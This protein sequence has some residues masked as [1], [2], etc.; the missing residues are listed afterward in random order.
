M[1][2]NNTP[3]ALLAKKLILSEWKDFA[4]NIWSMGKRGHVLFPA[5]KIR[6]TIK[7]Y[8]R[9]FYATQQPFISFCYRHGSYQ[10]NYLTHVYVSLGCFSFCLLLLVIIN[11]T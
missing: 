5:G 3:S 8:S 4:P 7:V 6:Y 11:C 9:K 1:W 10:H 2:E